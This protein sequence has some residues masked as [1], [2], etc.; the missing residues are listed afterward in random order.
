MW[1]PASGVHRRVVPGLLLATRRIM[2]RRRL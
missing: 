2:E 1:G